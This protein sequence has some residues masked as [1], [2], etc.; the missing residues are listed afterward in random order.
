MIYILT[1]LFFYF[2]MCPCSFRTKRHTII[3]S[4]MMMM[5]MMMMNYYHHCMIV[6]WQ[7]ILHFCIA[8]S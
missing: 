7:T 5:M 4:F 3:S 8:Q 1:V 6:G 2:V